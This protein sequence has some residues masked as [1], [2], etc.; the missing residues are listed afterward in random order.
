ML[1][2]KNLVNNFVEE[3]MVSREFSLFFLSSTGIGFGL[4]PGKKKSKADFHLFLF[5][6]NTHCQAC[7]I[8]IAPYLLRRVLFMKLF[9]L[10]VK[11]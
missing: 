10:R 1:S 11:L 5:L 7:D 4:I 6:L 9:F 2:N 3:I 8:R